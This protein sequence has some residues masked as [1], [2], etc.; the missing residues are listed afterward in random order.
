MFFKKKYYPVCTVLICGAFSLMLFS[1]YLSGLLR[2]NINNFFLPAKM[3][4]IPVKLQAH[5][6]KPLY[7]AKGQTGWDG[8]FYYYISNDLLGSR[9]TSVHIDAPSYRYQ[10]IGFPLTANIVSKLLLQKWVSP[11]LYFFTYLTLILVAVYVLSEFYREYNVP[12]FFALVWGMS[13]GVNLTLFNGLPDAAA[14]AYFILALF[15][16][17]RRRIFTYA[18]F[19]AMAV[20]TREA[21]LLIAF[22]IFSGE[23]LA[24]ISRLKLRIISVQ[25]M[26]KYFF[27]TLPG[28]LY[29]LWWSFVT[30]HFG[31]APQSESVG[32]LSWPFLTYFKYLF[33]YIAIHF[34]SVNVAISPMSGSLLLQV[35][36]LLFF[37]AIILTV[38]YLTIKCLLKTVEPKFK[39]L[40]LAILIYAFLQLCFGKTVIS[41]F[42][43]Y[44][45]A[46]GTFLVFIPLLLYKVQINIYKR[47]LIIGLLVF[48]AVFGIGLLYDRT[49]A[50][51]LNQMRT[52]VSYS[53][54][55]KTTCFQ[56]YNQTITPIS[57]LQPLGRQANGHVYQ[58]LKKV[59]RRPTLY[60][61]YVKVINHG[62]QSIYTTSGVGSFNLSYQIV[63]KKTG[64]MIADGVRTPLT[65]ISQPHSVSYQYMLLSLPYNFNPT[66]Q[67]VIF[68][69]V[70]EGCSWLYLKKPSLGTDYE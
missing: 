24:D 53:Q 41:D 43:G 45:K 51:A 33:S 25:S 70:Q 6:I 20:L 56:H 15:F 64:R 26:L 18:A 37:M 65:H 36:S 52:K 32:I 12:V 54:H 48:Y 27:V 31:E 35:V 66:T 42:S 38:F 5:G 69:L 63:D 62:S 10:R 34:L 17:L 47:L 3:F 8:Q 55:G 50:P 7:T 14:Q 4:G 40:S 23:F 22:V 21:Y 28:V 2:G 49:S 1:F 60:K 16:Y 19:M 68:S 29:F 61:V 57:N 44:L 67:K 39:I 11:T 58:F 9:A 46:I 59:W 13:F 30:F